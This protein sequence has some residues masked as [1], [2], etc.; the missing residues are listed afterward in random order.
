MPKKVC[1]IQG[2]PH[3]SARH[4]C[5]LL[6]D[7]Y[8]EG[9][10]AAGAQV[11]WVDIG[12]MDVPIMRDPADFMKAPPPSILSAQQ[13]VKACDHLV[14]VYPIWLGTMPALV[15]AFFEQLCRANFAIG[16]GGMKEWPQQMLKGKSAR[17]IVTM[18]MPSAAYR[19][20]FGAN[21]VKGFESG[22]LGMAG[23]KPIRE[24]F[25]GGVGQLNDKKTAVLVA[26]VRRLGQTLA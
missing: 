8:G 20:I 25:V 17:V 23:I 26:R 15:K 5:H 11:R 24:T 1:I 21:G 19:L 22:I 18:G 7:A 14:I 6:A 16:P 12:M 10:R 4:L 9:A 13:A 2:H 3:G